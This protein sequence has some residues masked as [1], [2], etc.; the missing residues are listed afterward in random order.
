[1]NPG[2]QKY[3]SSLTVEELNQD[4]KVLLCGDNNGGMLADDILAELEKRK[5]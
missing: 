3:L 1:M 4:L 5:Q 2:K